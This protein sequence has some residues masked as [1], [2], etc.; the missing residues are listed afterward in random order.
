[1]AIPSVCKRILSK[2]NAAEWRE[3]Q[4]L[5]NDQCSSGGAVRPADPMK[6]FGKVAGHLQGHKD[7]YVEFIRAKKETQNFMN[8]K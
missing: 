1:M 7:G 6:V 2:C 5:S 3:I 8:A 4:A